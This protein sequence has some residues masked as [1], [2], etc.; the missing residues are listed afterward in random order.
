MAIEMPKSKLTKTVNPN[1][2]K[3]PIT[4]PTIAAMLDLLSEITI[5]VCVC[6]CVCVCTTKIIGIHNKVRYS[7]CT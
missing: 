1:T 4:P 5:K 7:P 6:V 2:I 3:P